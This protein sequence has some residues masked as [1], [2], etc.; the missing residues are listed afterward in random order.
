MQH[1]LILALAVMV[2][3]LTA[4]ACATAPTVVDSSMTPSASA[5]AT[6]PQSSGPAPLHLVAIG[7]SIPYNSPD[8]CPGCQGFVARYAEAL[9][10]KTGRLVT[11]DNLSQHNGLDLPGLLDELDGFADQLASADAIIVGI[12]HNTI[13]IN[14][15]NPCGATW[16]EATST[17]SDWSKITPACSKAS[18]AKRKPQ[19]QSLFSQVAS[20]RAGKPTILL[21]IKSTTISSAGMPGT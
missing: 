2:S 1:R 6:Q 7:D 12:A 15:D 16:D 17:L 3:T 9:Q 8:D 13:E 21:T 18:V 19:F 11:V 20:L 4:A 5:S 14:T 10:A